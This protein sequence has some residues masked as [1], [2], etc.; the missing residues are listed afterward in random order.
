VG[1]GGKESEGGR[2]AEKGRYGVRGQLELS[3]VKNFLN[4]FQ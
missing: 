1:G 4:L 3:V 2:G